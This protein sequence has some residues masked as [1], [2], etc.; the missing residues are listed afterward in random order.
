MEISTFENQIS[1][2]KNGYT[3]IEILITL[4]I[5]ALLFSFGYASFRDFS[6][7][8]ALSNAVGAVQGDLRIAQGDSATGQKPAGCSD[9]LI[10]YNFRIVTT[11]P[12][13]YV[14][15]AIC[16]VTKTTVKDVTLDP[17]II[18]SNPGPIQF[19]VLD[20][21]TNAGD[22]NWIL[23]FTQAGTS[24]TATVTV[25]TGGNIQ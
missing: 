10:A 17:S 5:V 19:K 9:T 12:A 16:G 8:Q 18:L 21:G 4:T 13:E 22:S 1:D 11:S 20:Q 6:R 3:L 24:S 23:T 7:R 25:T 15:E 2:S 14:I